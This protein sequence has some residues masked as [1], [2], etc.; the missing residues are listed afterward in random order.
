MLHVAH[1]NELRHFRG[2]AKSWS[3][4]SKTL[5]FQKLSEQIENQKK[6]QQAKTSQHFQHK[7]VRMKN[8]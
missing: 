8:F 7:L 3:E 6:E 1:F 2:K 4:N 5:L